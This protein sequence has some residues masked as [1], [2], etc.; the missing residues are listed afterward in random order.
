MIDFASAAM[1]RVLAQGLRELG[2]D[3][4]ELGRDGAEARVALQQK[5]DLVCRAV[6]QGGLH[7]LPLLGR[8]LHRLRHEPTHQALASARS[9]ADL[10]ERWRRLE[11]Y[12]HSRHRCE[13]LSCHED[14]AGGRAEVRHVAFGQAASVLPAPSPAEDFVVAGVLAALLESLGLRRVQVRIDGAR[15][16]PDLDGDAL[17]AAA[18]GATAL[19]RFEWEGVVAKRLEAAQ[20]ASRPTSLEPDPAWPE[21]ARAAYRMM[22][23]DLTCPPTLRELAELLGFPVRTLQRRLGQAG[24]SHSRLLSE[25]RCRC[26]AWRLLRAADPIAEVGFLSGF[27]DQAH[28]TRELRRRVGLPPAAYRAAFGSGLP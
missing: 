4:G 19:W 22:L 5:Q 20:A 26:G 16:L 3:A 25:A 1:I 12:I 9:A 15:A 8:G 28:F 14:A 17:A 18:R 24:L 11:R 13:V 23:D 7:C 6:A 21:E 27:A 10:F 2:L